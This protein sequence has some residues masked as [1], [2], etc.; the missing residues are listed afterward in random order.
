MPQ[1]PRSTEY[2]IAVGYEM[3]PVLCQVLG[4][5]WVMDWILS[6]LVLSQ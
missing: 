3:V 1:R 4:R 5:G 6:Y 2:G